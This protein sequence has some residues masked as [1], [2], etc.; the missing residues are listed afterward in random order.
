MC[1]YPV[2]L[3]YIV[4]AQKCYFCACG[5]RLHNLAPS[6]RTKVTNS[7]VADDT[8]VPCGSSASRAATLSF[9]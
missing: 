4:E 3:Y 5:L 9:V 8:Y 6:Q 7:T 2:V 1:Q